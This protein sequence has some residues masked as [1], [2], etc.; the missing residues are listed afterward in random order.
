[1]SKVFVVLYKKDLEIDTFNIRG[2]FHTEKRAL[3]ESAKLLNAHIFETTVGI[4]KEF[5]EQQCSCKICRNK[6]LKFELRKEHYSY[7]ESSS[8][9]RFDELIELLEGIPD[10]KDAISIYKSTCATEKTKSENNLSKQLFT[11]CS[12]KTQTPQPSVS[13]ALELTKMILND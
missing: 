5:D 11:Y 13:E 9:R 3:Y 1:M 12:K 7:S 2:I 4:V 8:K 6:I 10:L